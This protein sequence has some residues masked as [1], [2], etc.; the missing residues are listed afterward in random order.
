MA[1]PDREASDSQL[2]P[3][4]EISLDGLFVSDLRFL[5]VLTRISKRA[6]LVQKVP[7]LVE[8]C[9]K[10]FQPISLCLAQLAARSPLPQFVFLIGEFVDPIDDLFV[11]HRFP[12]LG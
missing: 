2:A 10:P 12:L 6:A 11:L 5:G 8:P 1:S 3:L 4:T 7:A 9:L